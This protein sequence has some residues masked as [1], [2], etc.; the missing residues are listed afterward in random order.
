MMFESRLTRLEQCNNEL[1][2]ELYNANQKI[3]QLQEICIANGF[4]IPFWDSKHPPSFD[5]SSYEIQTAETAINCA[6]FAIDD[7]DD[8]DDDEY[9]DDKDSG[10]DYNE[11]ATIT[12]QDIFAQ[13]LDFIPVPLY[14]E[15]EEQEQEQEKKEQEEEEDNDKAAEA[16]AYETDGCFRCGR[17]LAE[18]KEYEDDYDSDDEDEDSCYYYC[19]KSLFSKKSETTRDAYRYYISKGKKTFSWCR[20]TENLITPDDTAQTP[21]DTAQ[22]PDDTATPDDVIQV[23]TDS[24]LLNEFQNEFPNNKMT[25]D[26]KNEYEYDANYDDA[27]VYDNDIYNNAYD[28]YEHEQHHHS[29]SSNCHCMYS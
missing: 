11:Q 19:G 28:E 2:N 21:D 27:P 14:E 4:T 24:Y 7:D 29:S 5:N 10:V 22:T 1:T 17:T 25:I 3:N 9:D 23:Y 16:R 20:D 12:D 8:D 13:N 26:E 6:N 15:Q 18:L